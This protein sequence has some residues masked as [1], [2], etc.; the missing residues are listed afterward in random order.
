[1]RVG[2]SPQLASG[3]AGVRDYMS[4]Y[5]YSC[6]EQQ[7][8]KAV[9]LQDLDAWGSLMR[10]LPGYLD[11]DGL[12][13]Y[14]PG[15]NH[16]SDV[17][18]AY[19][20]T[21]SAAAGWKLPNEQ[22]ARMSAGLRAFVQGKIVRRS[23]VRAPDLALRKIA[24]LAALAARDPKLDPHL[25]DSIAIE[26][27]RWPTSAVLDW[28]DLLSR[29]T[30]IPER[31]KRLAD[32]ENIIRTRLDLR[33]SVLRFSTANSDFLWWLMA[34]GDV[35]ANRTILEFV[36]DPGWR[37]DMPRLVR[38]ALER[39]HGGHWD[40]TV[41]NAW[42]VLALRRFSQKFESVP[43]IGTTQAKF[44][45]QSHD[46]DWHV[47]PKGGSVDFAWPKQP[48]KLTLVQHG[49]GKPWVTVQSR[50]AVPL[51]EPLASG[52]AIT[53]SVTPVRQKEKGIWR[54]GDVA[55]VKLV[56]DAQADMTWVVVRDPVPPG[57]T[58][59]G[60]GLGGD[61]HILTQGENDSSHLWPAFE[62]RTAD[63]YR[64]YYDYVPKGKWTLQYTVRLNNAGRFELPPTR[65]EALYAPETFGEV[66]NAAMTVK[67]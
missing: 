2:L 19:V 39:R 34:S 53:R 61:S 66:P 64:A 41:A 43:V 12:L 44:A 17:L 33:G 16:G 8:S 24:A 62:E 4:T 42:G 13:K 23:G 58:I 38:G 30:R 36:D 1:V 54:E 50:A 21:I 60:S 11:D 63:S 29:A 45:G 51:K 65:V 59:L 28:R 10:Q 46:F 15:M 7:T 32:A 52:F 6:F 47:K 20:L 56:I 26:P 3:L 22:L 55:R 57:A 27:E 48:A 49:T 14:F 25:L 9:A 37:S 35:N 31:A 67:Q 5:P 18:T 40:T